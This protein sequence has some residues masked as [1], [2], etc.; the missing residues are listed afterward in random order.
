MFIKVE[1]DYFKDSNLKGAN[2]ILTYS[3]LCDRMKA[4]KNN[5]DFFDKKFGDSYIIFKR[6]ELAEYLDVT[7]KTVTKIL[8]SLVKKGYLIVKHQFNAASKLFLPKFENEKSTSMPVKEEITPS[9][10]K[11]LPSNKSTLTDKY[12]TDNTDNTSSQTISLKD[13]NIT[14]KPVV[15]KP[16]Q[17]KVIKQAELDV[18]ANSLVTKVH[19]P[20]QAVNIMKTFSFGDP[21]K[22]YS[23]AGLLFKAKSAVSKQAKSVQN[24]QEALSFEL[25]TDYQKTLDTD[26]KRIIVSA[27]KKTSQPEGYMMTSLMDMFQNKVNDYCSHDVQSVIS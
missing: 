19:L 1:M 26:L 10:G 9:F 2:E 8:K 20:K 6:E 23:Y 4:S 5:K 13:S 25:N 3:L 22:L 27:N 7:V 17:N 12:I 21:K 11:N 24:A 16:D 14:Q 18:I 15:Q